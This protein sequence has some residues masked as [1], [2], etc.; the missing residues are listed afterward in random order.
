MDEPSPQSPALSKTQQLQQAWWKNII[1]SGRFFIAASIL[2][3]FLYRMNI[4]HLYPLGAQDILTFDGTRLFWEVQEW[5]VHSRW[6]HDGDNFRAQSSLFKSHKGTMIFHIIT[7]Q[8]NWSYR[9]GHVSSCHWFQVFGLSRAVAA[10][11]FLSYSTSAFIYSIMHCI[12]HSKIALKGQMKKAKECH[13]KHHMSP[14]HHLNMGPN[15]IDR[16][17]KTDSYDT[18]LGKEAKA[19]SRGWIV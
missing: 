6:F 8:L 17:M 14:A 1:R 19:S 15:N 7:S 10:T 3:T 9:S 11:M 12:C 18:R 16:L 13:I 2:S 4:V 5:A